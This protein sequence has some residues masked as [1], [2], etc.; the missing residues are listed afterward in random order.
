M[1]PRYTLT[2]LLW[3]PPR[4]TIARSKYT[5]AKL[6]P[7]DLRMRV[8]VASKRKGKKY[9]LKNRQS[10]V[11]RWLLIR[12]GMFKR[13]QAG[14]NHLNLNNRANKTRRKRRRVLCTTTQ[15]R[16]LKKLIP[17]WKKQYMK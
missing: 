16:R 3:P 10:A 6:T 13:K 9:K 12:G 4:V 2:N 1:T 7:G 11:T 5:K 17:Y 8:K 14:T 15:R